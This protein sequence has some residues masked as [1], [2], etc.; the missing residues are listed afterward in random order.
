M[1]KFFQ[2]HKALIYWIRAHHLPVD[3][4]DDPKWDIEVAMK[5][6]DE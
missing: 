4:C 5:L 1:A 2:I 3:R 6:L